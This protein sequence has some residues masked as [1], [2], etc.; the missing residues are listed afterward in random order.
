MLVTNP[1]VATL[2]AAPVTESLETAGFVVKACTVPDGEAHKT[3]DT[4]RML[5]DRF[6]EAGLDRSGVVLALGGGVIGDMAGFAA[7]TYLRGVALVQVPTTL[8]AMVDSSVGGKVAV[9][10][11]WGK[12]LVGAF[13]QPEL[14]LAD[15]G[16]LTTLPGHEFAN[17]LAE[18]IKA[19]ILGDPEMFH[20]IEAHGPAPASWIVERAISVKVAVVEE[21]P[22]ERGRRA[23]LN[24]GHTFG[25]A[26]ERLS[27][28]ALSH[29]AGVAIG[30]VA[31][32]RLATRLGACEPELAARIEGVLSRLGLPT[33]YRGH[34]PAQVWQAMSTDKKRRGKTLRFVLPRAIG[35][36]F[37]TDQVAQADVLAILDSLR[38]T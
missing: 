11:P 26:L 8:L 27:D 32:A 28:Y 15:P 12:N 34:T 13:K 22:Y 31:A 2:Y 21:D 14:V 35:D 5:Y 38:E 3:L 29:G 33:T 36:A 18:T 20:Q 37:V 10:H 24:L 30:L 16:T 25:H 1:T 17:G 23:T 4:V 7:A 9:D 19:G 6:I